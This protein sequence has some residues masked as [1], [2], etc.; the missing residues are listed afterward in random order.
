MRAIY[1]GTVIAESDSTELEGNHYFP[2][3]SVDMTL[4]GTSSTPYHC[5]WKGAAE[6]FHL[7]S[8]GRQIRDIAW[9]Y[10]EPKPAA[11]SI[12]GHVAFDQ[13][14]GVQLVR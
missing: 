9:S 14:K 13:R 10:P 3:S 7:D 4:L 8:D 5:P 11:R 2:R 6:Y 12:A 1:D